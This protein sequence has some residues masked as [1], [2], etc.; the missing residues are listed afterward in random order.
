VPSNPSPA[1]ASILPTSLQGH[2]IPPERL[3]LI[4]PH[5][6]ALAE[7]ALNVSNQLPLQADTADFVA[8]LEAEEG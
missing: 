2:D 5:I 7:T 4:T 6:K 1:P 8:T 3:A